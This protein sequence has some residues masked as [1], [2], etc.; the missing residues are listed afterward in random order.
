MPL[1]VVVRKEAEIGKERRRVPG[2]GRSKG[3]LKAQVGKRVVF[4]GIFF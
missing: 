2:E 1:A 3:G 4:L